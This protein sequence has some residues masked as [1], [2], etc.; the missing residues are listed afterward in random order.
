MGHLQALQKLFIADTAIVARV[1][2]SIERLNHLSIRW[3]IIRGRS[4]H[5]A[6]SIES[7]A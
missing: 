2:G 3:S 1:N 5:W 4:M 6:R 7:A